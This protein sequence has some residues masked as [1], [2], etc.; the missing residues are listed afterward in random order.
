MTWEEFI[1]AN[2]GHHMKDFKRLSDLVMDRQN[3]LLGHMIRHRDDIMSE[4]TLTR[5][6]SQY[7]VGY[8]RVGRPRQ[9]WVDSNINYYWNKTY[10]C[11]FQRNEE[12]IATLKYD[13]EQY[14]F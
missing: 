9:R 10:G 6:V 12:N 13:A 2:R 11:D 1:D 5:D 7:Q 3:S 4:V 8:R 14:R